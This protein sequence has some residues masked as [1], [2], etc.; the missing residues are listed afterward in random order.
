MLVDGRETKIAGCESCDMNS[1]RAWEKFQMSSSEV[2][3][4]EFCQL[5]FVGPVERLGRADAARE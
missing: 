1:L 5:G 2:G 4:G 3:V